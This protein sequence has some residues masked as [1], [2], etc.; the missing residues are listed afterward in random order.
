M[1]LF[2][3][4]K[5]AKQPKPKKISFTTLSRLA[6]ARTTEFNL[7]KMFEHGYRNKEDVSNLPANTLVV[8]SQNVLTNSSEQVAVRNGYELDGSDGT[9]NTYGIDSSY[10]FNS[11]QDGVR[12]LRK[13]GTTLQVRYVNP[14]SLAV[15]WIT[16]KSDL[17]ADNV[18]NFCDF[19]SSIN[20]CL[21]VNGNNNIWKWTGGMASFLSA[22][23][24]TVTVSGTKALSKLNFFSS[25]SFIIDGI[26]YKYT[27][28]GV[29]SSTAFSQTPTNN[30]ILATPTQW[31][32]QQFTT[33][34]NATEILTAVCVT[35]AASG[36][37]SI[38]AN[39]TGAIYTDNAGVPGT[40]VGSVNASEPATFSA[41]DYTITFTFDNLTVSPATVY[42]FVIYSDLASNMAVYTGASGTGVGTNISIDTGTTWSAQS[43]YLNLII[44]ENDISTRTFI[45]V[46]PD[47]S[48]AVIA[49]GDAIVQ[50][51]TLGTSAVKSAPLTKF[52]LIAQFR[53]QIY[54]GDFD[55]N[56]VY[57]TAVNSFTDATV[58]TTRVV[59]EGAT[60]TLDA[61]PIGFIAQDDSLAI[62]AGT[63]YW[64]E[65]K[66]TLSSDNTKEQFDIVRLKT[67]VSQG[68][69]SQALMNKMKNNIIFVSNEEIFNSL[70]T[71][72]NFLNS[73]Q[74]T[75]MSD[76][77]KYDMLGYDFTGGAVDYDRF[78][79]Y[80]MIPTVSV[81]RMY[82]LEKKYWEAP[83]IMPV[84]R[85]YRVDG[86][87]YAHS[88]L[89]DESYKIFVDGLYNDNGNPIQAVAAF[90]YVSQ[91]GGSAPQKKNFN[92]HFTEGYIAGNT[93]LTLTVNY[94]FGGYSGSYSDIIDGS[95]LTLVFNKIT[96]GSL[97]QN[98]LGS[99]PI[100]S[101]LNLAQNPVIPKFRKISTFPRK[102][103]FE[104]QIVYSSN[105][106]DYNWSLLR[107]GPAIK[108]AEDIPVEITQ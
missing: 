82:N 104:Y 91:V 92:K 47:P 25:G 64:Y 87:L 80:L 54:Y 100:G 50:T 14:V 53:N 72:Q 65:T 46:T 26:T 59:G 33:G 76:P 78:F 88:S 27:G 49:V 23:T 90:P 83:Q 77:I 35:N 71:T 70:G 31:T 40:L 107:F 96:D 19:F 102:N 103:V 32:S 30:K 20:Y 108:S 36:P 42:H 63:D 69:K 97:G 75:N 39:Y 98:S 93:S 84:S 45:G 79:L 106:V 68:A 51:V 16:I 101:V 22:T 62:S 52:D 55:N 94:D 60:V 85:L 57:I 37:N 61:P 48:L 58:S 5:Q 21:F 4:P 56:N 3:K 28:A 66:F 8:G 17:S 44:T 2:N 9:Q 89:T 13:W 11:H 73:P 10:D 1:P 74:V 99:Q 6:K 86:A 18:V 43:G 12:N 105:E 24:S 38:T 41:G 15:S 95:D 67:L 29:S 7:Q 34:A 81:I